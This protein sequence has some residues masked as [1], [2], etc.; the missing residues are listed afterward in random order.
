MMVTKVPW[1][2]IQIT[3]DPGQRVLGEFFEKKVWDAVKFDAKQLLS[4]VTTATQ[5][6]HTWI[7]KELVKKN[8]VDLDANPWA[9][10][11]GHYAGLEEL[12]KKRASIRQQA[13]V[14]AKVLK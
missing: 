1:S 12:A 7:G 13:A 2:L 11:S 3:H 6:L 8:N 10:A 14:L 9:S 4:N 5:V